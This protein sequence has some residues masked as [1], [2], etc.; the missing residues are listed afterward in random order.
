MHHIP[1][2]KFKEVVQN[3]PLV[4]I[5][6]IIENINGEIL[7]GWRN[8]HPAKGFW[9]VPGGRIM[10]NEKFEDA[11]HR[12][13]L[14]ETG[15]DLKINDTIFM[16]IYEHFYPNEDFTGISSFGTH[17]VVIAF[18]LKLISSIENLPKEQHTEYWW[19]SIDDLLDDVN[20]HENVRNYFN[21]HISLTG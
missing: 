4:S 1:P 12:I 5:D 13:A 16:G 14:D 19:A 21:G 6:L 9:F 20:V 3:T 18:R 8:N 10:K 7:V 11:F 15:L 2:E 17:Y